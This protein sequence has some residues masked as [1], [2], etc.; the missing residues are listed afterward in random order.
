[1]PES[2]IVWSELAR[3][4]ISAVYLMHRGAFIASKLDSYR[5]VGAVDTL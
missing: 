1:M 5:L 4:P 2:R 3:D